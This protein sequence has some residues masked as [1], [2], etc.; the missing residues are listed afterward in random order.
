MPKTSNA[1]PLKTVWQAQQRAQLRLQ[2]YA[3]GETH[4]ILNEFTAKA[5]GLVLASAGGKEKSLDGLRL[6]RAVGA[7][8]REWSKTFEA[9]KKF[10]NIVRHDSAALPFETLLV[11]HDQMVMPAVER[12]DRETNE[13]G[14][15]REILFAH[16]ALCSWY[17]WSVEESEPSAVSG[18]RSTVRE[19][20]EAGPAEDVNFVFDPQLRAVMDAA[21]QRVY[22]DGLRLSQRIWKLNHDSRSGMNAVLYNGVAQSKSAWDI[23]QDLEAYLG[24]NQD[25]PRW[26][27]TRLYK[28]TKGQIAAGD[29]RGLLRAS[30]CD[31]RGV[32][33][34]A[35]RMA[36]TELQAVHNIATQDAMAKMPWIEQEQVNLSKA[37]PVKD[38]CDEKARG[39]EGG[40][41]IYP[42]GTNKLPY[43]PN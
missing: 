33:Y 20:T 19:F 22:R 28:L 23:A 35:L 38:I 1:I 9:W 4:R 16:P 7:L 32:A 10:F 36:R 11:Y 43:H 34:N 14:E 21:D 31:G 17:W 27:S 25:C 30:E 15:S 8:E 6:H 5:R 26:T 24:A 18:R 3:T 12:L 40:K 37:H 13:M 41:G 2:L 39:G 29:P 42:K